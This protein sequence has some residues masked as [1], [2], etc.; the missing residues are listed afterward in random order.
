MWGVGC[1]V[2]GVGCGVWGVG[3]GVWGVGIINRPLA[4]IKNLTL[5]EESPSQYSGVRRIKNEH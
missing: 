3:C 5:G 4:K 2:W 1:G